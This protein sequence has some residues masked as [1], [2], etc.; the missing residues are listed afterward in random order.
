MTDRNTL[1][2]TFGM[3]GGPLSDQLKKQGYRFRAA[4]VGENL[5]RDADAI[6]RLHF[7]GYIRSQS[8]S[9]RMRKRLMDRLLDS[10]VP[11]RRRK[12]RA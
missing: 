9:D 5:Q 3:L 4:Q 10:I 1:K 2:I 8:T 11:I 12:G 7:G 6:T